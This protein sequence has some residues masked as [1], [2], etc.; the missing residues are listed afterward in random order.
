MEVCSRVFVVGTL[1]VPTISRTKRLVEVL[2]R[3]SHGEQPMFLVINRYA[4]KQN[5][6]LK[7]AEETLRIK[8]GWLIPNDYVTASQALERGTPL[9]QL[10]PR[11]DLVK[12]YMKQATAIVKEC[13]QAAGDTRQERVTSSKGKNSVLARLW[14][15]F[16]SNGKANGGLV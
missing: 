16:A 5:D 2:Q 9:V 8:A 3:L 12:E 13:T 6:L 14:P 11:T 15:G 4:A 7:Q 10:A 1:N